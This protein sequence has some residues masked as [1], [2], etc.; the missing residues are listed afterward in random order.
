MGDSKSVNNIHKT[1]T[2]IQLNKSIRQEPLK[3][4]G[5]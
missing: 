2:S 4:S 1:V 3:E 5:M